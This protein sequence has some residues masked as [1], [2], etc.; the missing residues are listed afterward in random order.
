[1]QGKW[2]LVARVDDP[3][4]VPDIEAHGGGR[5]LD[6]TYSIQFSTAELWG[7]GA[8]PGAAVHVD[9][10]ERYLEEDT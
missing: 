9:V 8:E 7:E 4:N 10:W 5:V 1:V 6:P 2:G 3:A